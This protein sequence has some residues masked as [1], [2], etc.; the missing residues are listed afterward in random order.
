M[1]STDQWIPKLISRIAHEN[2][3]KE[4]DHREREDTPDTDLDCHEHGQVSPTV[5]DEDPEVL[6]KD[7][8][9]DEEDTSNVDDYGGVEPLKARL[10]INRTHFER[11]DH[12]SI[13]REKARSCRSHAWIP[14]PLLW[15][16]KEGMNNPQR[17]IY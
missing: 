8:E 3:Q 5:R 7:R 9:L 13:V 6:E 1:T 16:N 10:V 11:I 15:A 2:I 17:P 14:A 4:L 12:T